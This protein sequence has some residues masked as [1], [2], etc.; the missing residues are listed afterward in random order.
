MTWSRPQELFWSKQRAN[1][2]QTTGKQPS[3]TRVAAWLLRV[4]YLRLAGTY[5]EAW[6]AS[7]V[8]KHMI[9]AA[10]FITMVAPTS[11]DL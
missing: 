3:T 11:E 10:G 6:M 7:C 8:V 5:Y 4:T 9:E 1:D 2:E